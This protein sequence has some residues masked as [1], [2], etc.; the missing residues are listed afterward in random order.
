MINQ[1]H[2]FDDKIK[3]EQILSKEMSYLLKEREKIV[4]DEMKRKHRKEK[5]PWKK[6]D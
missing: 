6:K 4:L 2:I 3:K 5:T 1:K